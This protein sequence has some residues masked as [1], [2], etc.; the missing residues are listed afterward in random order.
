[1]ARAIGFTFAPLLDDPRCLVWDN[2]D[3]AGDPLGG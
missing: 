3:A 1:M 2:V